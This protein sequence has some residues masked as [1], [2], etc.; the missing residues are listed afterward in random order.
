MQKNKNKQKWSY[1]HQLIYICEQHT[2]ISPLAVC[3]KACVCTER[4]FC[5]ASQ[6][7]C[8]FGVSFALLYAHL[9]VPNCAHIKNLTLLSTRKITL[10]ET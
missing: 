3:T 10:K 6:K 4:T 7:V 8:G 9:T 2:C 1:P 5:P